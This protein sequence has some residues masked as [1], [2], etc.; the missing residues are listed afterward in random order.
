MFKNFS[1][2]LAMIAI[3]VVLYLAGYSYA[4]GTTKITAKNASDHV[5]SLVSKSNSSI[6]QINSTIHDPVSPR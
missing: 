3:A 5:W 1:K 2:G 4:E 6:G